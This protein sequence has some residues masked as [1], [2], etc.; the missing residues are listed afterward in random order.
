MTPEE[1]AIQVCPNK[2][3]TH[4]RGYNK[5]PTTVSCCSM[6]QPIAEVI[7][8]AVEEEKERCAYIAQEHEI[9]VFYD[10]DCT[11]HGCADLIANCIRG[12]C[13]NH[14]HGG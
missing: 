14:S 8:Q 5:F 3:N 9:M 2:Y 13:K 11:Q 10:G 12:Q 4:F 6:C 1:R 7:K